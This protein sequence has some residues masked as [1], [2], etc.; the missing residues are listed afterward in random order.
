MSVRSHLAHEGICPFKLAEKLKLLRTEQD[1]ECNNL[2]TSFGLVLND[3]H[4]AITEHN[5]WEAV[6]II[7]R[8]AD[9]LKSQGRLETAEQLFRLGIASLSREFGRYHETTL[10]LAFH[11]GRFLQGMRAFDKAVVLYRM[12]LE[13]IGKEDPYRIYFLNELGVACAEARMLLE[14]EDALQAALKGCEER[15]GTNNIWAHSAAANLGDIYQFQDRLI[16]AAIMLRRGLVGI[17]KFCAASR[18]AIVAKAPR[19]ANIYQ[20]LRSRGRGEEALAV[21]NMALTTFE[22]LFGFDDEET[23]GVV[24]DL[25][26]ISREQGKLEAYKRLMA[27]ALLSLSN[28]PTGCAG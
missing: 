10:V 12:S 4:V 17:S 6:D 15:W 14:A 21:C 22:E 1:V 3:F 16:E 23:L 20:E 25:A 24:W 13:G 8:Y 18:K 28:E 26:L 11:M 19:L 7:I 9:I 2:A 27:R 5:Q